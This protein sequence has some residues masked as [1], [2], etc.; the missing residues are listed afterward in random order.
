MLMERAT[1][2]AREFDLRT[3]DVGRITDKLAREL[4]AGLRRNG[5]TQIPSFVTTVPNGLE[6]GSYL[7][8]DLGGTNCRIC[9]V[10]LQGHGK[11]TME[12]RKHAIPR[13]IRVNASCKPLFNFIAGLL[14]EFLA[15]TSFAAAGDQSGLKLGFTFSFTYISHSLS[16]GTVVQWDKG[17]DLP[18]ALGRDPCLLLQEAIDDIDLGVRVTALTNDSVGTLM[19]RAYTSPWPSATLLGAIFGTGTNA[20][21]VERKRNICKLEGISQTPYADEDGIM[22]VNTEWGAMCDCS[23]SVLPRCL[24]DDVL[25]IASSNPRSQLLEKQISGLYLG[26]LMRLAMMSLLDEKLFGMSVTDSSP[27]YH[28]YAIDTSF[29]SQVLAN[30]TQ[31]AIGEISTTLQAQ[32]VTDDDLRALQWVAIA[33][34]KRS[35]RLAGAAMAAIILQ[36]ERLS[37]RVSDDSS[38]IKS[39]GASC[40]SKE[41]AVPSPPKDRTYSNAYSRFK[42]FVHAIFSCWREPELA[43]PVT[44]RKEAASPLA[45]GPDEMH[46]IID[47]GVDGSLYEYCPNFEHYLREAL[48]EIPAIGERGESRIRLGLSK[49]GSGVGAALVTHGT[50]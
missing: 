33:I 15:G 26:E 31:L 40:S 6:K 37:R 46:S 21:Y 34:T 23:D 19:A 38:T 13:D 28:Q 10:H 30:S 9:L 41:V 20:A 12:Q 4:R 17:W 25:D 24:Y 29:L 42:S 1:E 36:S 7:V 18:D 49:D 27:I 2:I 39:A 32:N 22:V 8:V 11:Y 43:Q 44:P 16:R 45:E 48:R 14:R 3:E 35:A 47:I 5:A 50:A